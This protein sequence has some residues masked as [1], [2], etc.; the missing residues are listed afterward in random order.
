M[1]Y[2]KDWVLGSPT[3]WLPSSWLIRSKLCK[4]LSAQSPA[5]GFDHSKN[6]SISKSVSSGLCLG[7][8]CAKVQAIPSAERRVYRTPLAPPTGFCSVGDFSDGKTYS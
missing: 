7:R 4:S 2:N 6:R 5:T 3:M 8:G 1:V